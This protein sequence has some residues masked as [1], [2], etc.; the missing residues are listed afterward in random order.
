MQKEEIINYIIKK[1]IIERAVPKGPDYED[2]CQDIYVYVLEKM[3]KIYE[4]Y[5]ENQ[6]DNKAIDAYVKSIIYRQIRSDTS[7]IY[8]K[9][10]LYN[11][12][13]QNYNEDGWDRIANE[14]VE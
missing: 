6:E 10:D 4:V 5:Q 8:Y 13:N 9:Y 7:D 11:N 1:K 14:T 3:D 12:K 2:I